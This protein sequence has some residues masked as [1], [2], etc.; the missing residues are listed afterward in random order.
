S[1]QS[2]VRI[3]AATHQ[4]LESLV[5]EGRFRE[6]LFH[7]LN[8]IRIHIPP[9]RERQQDIPLLMRHFLNQASIELETEIKILRTE[10]E[11]F[12]TKLPWLGNVRQ[13][14][15]LCRWLTV[16][17]VSREI[18]MDDLPPELLNKKTEKLLQTDNKWETLLAHK[19]TETMQA[20][21]KEI[22]KEIIPA[23]ERILITEALKHTHG[24]RHEAA[25]LLGYG[26]NTL[27][28]KIKELGL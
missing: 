9:L 3:I 18:Y 27:T 11:D 1:V 8:V 12:L 10:T 13:L 7:R 25:I 19:I 5:E 14:E 16:M 28:R 21:G 4:D 24:K 17:G 2:D 6:D 20:N 23:V 15:N 22:A 26:R